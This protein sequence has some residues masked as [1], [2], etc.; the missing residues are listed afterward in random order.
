[1]PSGKRA[2]KPFKGE[3]RK[4]GQKGPAGERSGQEETAVTA[5]WMSTKLHIG[6][7]GGILEE[8]RQ[9]WAHKE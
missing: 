1:M 3:I 6:S 4:Q 9:T 2:L 8:I 5:G 7:K